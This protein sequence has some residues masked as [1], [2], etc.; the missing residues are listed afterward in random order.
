MQSPESQTISGAETPTY[1]VGQQEGE[2]ER[3]VGRD[4]VAVGFLAREEAW[5]IV[6]LQLTNCS[7]SKGNARKSRSLPK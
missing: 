7:S 2:G 5:H 6:G 3:K 4:Q 1:V